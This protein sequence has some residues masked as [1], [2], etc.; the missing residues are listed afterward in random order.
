M[1]W[2]SRVTLERSGV[3]IDALGAPIMGPGGGEGVREGAEDPVGCRGA[4]RGGWE[5]PPGV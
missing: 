4:L 1:L 2:G 3:P 5:H